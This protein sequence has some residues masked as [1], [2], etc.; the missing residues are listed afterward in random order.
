MVANLK[1]KIIVVFI[2][3]FCLIA[4][5]FFNDFKSFQTITANS[6]KTPWYANDYTEPY[7]SLRLAIADKSDVSEYWTPNA[8]GSENWLVREVKINEHVFW[9]I[10][11]KQK[12]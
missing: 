1:E 10:L 6:Y 11:E 3:I 4:L 9:T 8:I 7:T 2:L 12:I 5:I